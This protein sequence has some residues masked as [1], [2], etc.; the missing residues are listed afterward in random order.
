MAADQ[1]IAQLLAL[2]RD[3]TAYQNPLFQAVT[4]MAYRGLPTY[5]RE[6][7]QLSGSLSNQIPQTSQ[8]GGGMN[9]AL[10][11]ALGAGGMGALDALMSHGGSNNAVG[12]LIEGLK[13]LFGHRGGNGSVQGDEPFSGGALTGPN[14]LFSGYERTP[15]R[16]WNTGL[17][18][19]QPFLTSDPGFYTGMTYPTD[20]SR[21]TGV[22]P[23]MQQYYGAG[24]WGDTDPNEE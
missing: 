24:F 11:A 4:Q 7:T 15:D 16:S 23:G 6:G 5:A 12:A 22:G 19:E 2:S 9:P 20:P 3:R 8:S 21:G 17:P 13:K 10:A 18:Y 1:E 14:T